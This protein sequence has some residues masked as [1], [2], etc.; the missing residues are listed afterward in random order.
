MVDYEEILTATNKLVDEEKLE[1]IAKLIDSSKR[2]YFYGIGSSGLVAMEIKSRFMRL[3][4]ICD[5]ITDKTI[6]FGQ[7]LF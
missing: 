4:V 1:E 6:L 3:G 5:A 7:L 2:V